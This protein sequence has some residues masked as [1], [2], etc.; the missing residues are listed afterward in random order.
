M[1]YETGMPA[2]ALTTKLSG[3]ELNKQEATYKNT[4]SEKWHTNAETAFAAKI[5]ACR[6]SF[7]V[8]DEESPCSR[9]FFTPDFSRHSLMWHFNSHASLGPL[10]SPVF[11]N[12]WYLGCYFWT[13]RCSM[14]NFLWYLEI[15]ILCLKEPRE[16]NRK[17][18]TWR[19]LS[20][21]HLCSSAGQRLPFLSGF[22]CS[23]CWESIWESAGVSLP[24]QITPPHAPS[25]QWCYVKAP[26]S[27]KAGLSHGV[28][29]QLHPNIC[30]VSP[31]GLKVREPGRP[32]R[33]SFVSLWLLVVGVPSILADHR[34]TSI[35]IKEL[36]NS[37]K[38]CLL[39]I[40]MRLQEALNS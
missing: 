23:T 11:Q 39:R 2:N 32:G 8:A 27:R 10:S 21:C 20:Q 26:A 22:V 4:E 25:W 1:K 7:T 29:L 38:R 37:R 31:S 36:T 24:N 28:S 12:L 33:S 6:W 15:Y 19:L 9:V 30:C 17:G 5:P 3:I 16:E 35:W 13:R 14:P 18:E 34:V 40:G